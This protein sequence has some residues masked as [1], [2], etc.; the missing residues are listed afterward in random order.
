MS[1]PQDPGGCDTRRDDA[2]NSTG[3]GAPNSTRRGRPLLAPARRA[4][5]R[6]VQQVRRRVPWGSTLVVVLVLAVT[7]A[8]G[9]GGGEEAVA[10]DDI[11]PIVAIDPCELLDAGTAEDLAGGEVGE[12]ESEVTDDGST[13]CAFSFRNA[14]AATSGSAIA[15]RLSIGPG[16]E[17]DVPGGALARAVSIGDAGAVEE[18][19]DKVRVVYVVR[20]VVVRVEVVPASGEVTPEL[21]EEVVRFTETTE[22]PVTEAV[23][24]EPFVPDDTTT[25]EP[26]PTTTPTTAAAGTPTTTTG[27]ST[28]DLWSRTAVEFRDRVGERF[29]FDCP[30]P[31]PASF[32]TVWGTGTYTDDSAVCVAAVHDGRIT[33]ESGGDV[34]IEMRPGQDEYPGSEANG[35]T[36]SDWPEWP[37]SFVFVQP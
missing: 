5:L 8:C 12:P 21:V 35:I 19:P 28:E 11:E 2:T 33:P 4:T 6:R 1:P 37:G 16:D 15:A 20:E 26:A 7:S 36:S 14:G 9:G 17:T 22:K 29:D 18:R 23:T 25:T 27:A 34:T 24:G 30:G 13:S 31:A 10:L 3:A 32:G